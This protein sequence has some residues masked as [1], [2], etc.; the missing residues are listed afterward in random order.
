[1]KENGYAHTG[2]KQMTVGRE[3]LD[4]RCETCQVY[5][6]SGSEP[7]MRKLQTYS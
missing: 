3:T 4:V 5:V 2:C 7:G 6:D 1:M